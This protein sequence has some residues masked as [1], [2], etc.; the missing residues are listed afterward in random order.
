MKKI[1]LVLAL[2]FASS[3]ANAQVAWPGQNW[4]VPPNNFNT[5]VNP[6]TNTAFTSNVNSSNPYSSSNGA[7]ND[8]GN[9]VF[10]VQDLSIYVP[11]NSNSVAGLPYYTQGSGTNESVW[12]APGNEVEIVPVPG[13]CNQYYV[14]YGLSIS[15]SNGTYSYYAYVMVDCSTGTPVVNTPTNF[16]LSTSSAGSGLAVSKVTTANKIRY[17]FTASGAGIIRYNIGEWSSNVGITGATTITSSGSS[18]YVYQ[19]ELSPDQT[20]LAWNGGGYNYYNNQVCEVTLNS[21]YGYSAFT[22]YTIPGIGTGI[23]YGLQYAQPTST[24]KRLYVA[25]TN[26]ITYFTPGA[27]PTYVNIASSTSYGNTQLQRMATGNIMGVSGSH[28]Y[29]INVANNTIAASTNTTPIYSNKAIG[30]VAAYLYHLPDGL[31]VV[32]SSISASITNTHAINGSNITAQGNCVTN[33]A[34]TNYSWSIQ[35]CNS[36]GTP[37]SGYS[38]SSGVITGI[39]TGAFTFPSTATLPCNTYY[40]INFQVSNCANSATA[41]QQMVYTTLDANFGLTASQINPTYFGATATYPT[42][43]PTSSPGFGYWWDVQQVGVS[44]T[45]VNNPSC[46]WNYPAANTFN[47]YNGTSTLGSCSSVGNFLMNQYYY[48]SF[49]VW[50]SACGWVETTQEVTVCSGNCRLANPDGVSTNPIKGQDHSSYLSTLQTASINNNVINEAFNVSI[51]P[52]PNNGNFTIETQA[53]TPQLVEMFDL[54]GRLVLSQTINTTANINVS[55]LTGG[56]Y[57]IKI[58]SNNNVVN[59]RVVISK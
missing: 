46:W 17:L 21:S 19:L 20:R 1:K 14:I 47:G 53:T 59:K 13:N 45:E 3:M 34:P 42:D 11:G 22:T 25:A 54:T 4:I 7:F 35:Q 37:I 23:I 30:G 41:P 27:S 24:T 36:S 43:N 18:D 16:P 26:G 8:S 50:S 33:L 15:N 39:P 58:S 6:P 38:W 32:T 29:E 12:D 31:D 57:N 2:A 5:T 48:I 49:G 40:L 55:D 52:N 44:G 56:I 51:Y 28:L 10:Y 9:L